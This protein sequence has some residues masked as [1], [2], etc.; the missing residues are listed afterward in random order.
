M[1]DAIKKAAAD[2]IERS[3]AYMQHCAAIEQVLNIPDTEQAC[4]VLQQYV[5]GL[6]GEAEFQGF[7]QALVQQAMMAQQALIQAQSGSPWGN[8]FEDRI[9]YATACIN[10]GEPSQ[11]QGAQ[12]RLNGLV[13]MHQLADR[14]WM[15]AQQAR[16][17]VATPQPP[18]SSG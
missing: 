17:A 11:Q 13:V 18:S 4:Y 5:H 16:A 2:A 14:F 6:G 12:M 10:S 15:E 1:W 9:A 3:A 7:K 8:S